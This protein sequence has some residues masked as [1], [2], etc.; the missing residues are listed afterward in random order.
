MKRVTMNRVIGVLGIILFLEAVPGFVLYPAEHTK[1][2]YL[3]PDDCYFFAEFNPENAFFLALVSDDTYTLINRE[4]MGVMVWDSGTWRRDGEGGVTLKSDKHFRNVERGPLRIFL[5]YDGPG[6]YL[7]QV[8]KKIKNF[9]DKNPAKEFSADQVKKISRYKSSIVDSIL[10]DFWC[11]KVKREELEALLD[12]I[13]LYKTSGNT[14]EFK[15]IPLEFNG[16]VFLQWK[17]HETPINRDPV[18]MIKELERLKGDKEYPLFFFTEIDLNVF[19]TEANTTQPFTY[20]KEM[21]KYRQEGELDT[22][23]EKITRQC[24]KK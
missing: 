16:R 11:G 15:F 5:W 14:N 13:D 2:K 3:N 8:Q 19:R 12:E 21:N 7:D 10:V 24:S 22:I 1:V 4:H 6:D 9:L 23:L 20:I 17:N 18:R